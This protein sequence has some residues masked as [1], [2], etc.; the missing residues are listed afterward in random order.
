VITAEGTAI[1]HRSAKDVLEFVLD[2]ERY[3]QAD[4]KITKIL[5]A[6]DLGDGDSGVAKYRGKLMGFP[7]SA[8]TTDVKLERWRSLTFS[9]VPSKWPGMI[10]SFEGSFTCEEV[11]E[12]TRVVHRETMNF[13]APGKWLAEPIVRRWF[14]REMDKEMQRLKALLES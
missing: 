11:A 3:K 7:T 12:G 8:D 5:Q 6:P 1:V 9:S 10:A 2:L 13:K 4:T 14:H